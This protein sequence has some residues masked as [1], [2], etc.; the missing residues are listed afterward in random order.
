MMLLADM[1]S[2]LNRDTGWRTAAEAAALF[3]GG[4]VVITESP[5]APGDFARWGFD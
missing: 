2:N 5:S 1:R 3:V 4:E